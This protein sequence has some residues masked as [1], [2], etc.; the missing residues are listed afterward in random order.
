MLPILTQQDRYKKDMANFRLQISEIKDPIILKKAED[1]LFEIK[2]TAE[3]IDDHILSTGPVSHSFLQ[4][5]KDYL[6][7]K[8]IELTQLLK[9]FKRSQLI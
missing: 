3:K 8:R 6:T 4:D 7:K 9:D 1:L 5:T 2:I